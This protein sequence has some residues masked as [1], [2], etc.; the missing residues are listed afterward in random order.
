MGVRARAAQ[1]ANRLPRSALRLLSTFALAFFFLLCLR[2][3]T[4]P[5]S[6]ADFVLPRVFLGNV[7]MADPSIC[8]ISQ[9]HAEAFRTTA[10]SIFSI[11]SSGYPRLHVFMLRL[12]AAEQ[13][14]YT[15]IATGVNDML[16]EPLVSILKLDAQATT[17]TFP[18]APPQSLSYLAT[19]LAMELLM[20]ATVRDFC[21]TGWNSLVDLERSRSRHRVCDTDLSQPLC[22]YFLFSSTGTLFANVLIPDVLQHMRLKRVAIGWNFV[23]SRTW[24]AHT[25]GVC[26]EEGGSYVHMTAAFERTRMENDAA[27]VLAEH[28]RQRPSLRFMADKLRERKRVQEADVEWAGGAFFERLAAEPELR[29]EDLVLMPHAWMLRQ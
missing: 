13:K 5:P 4:L 16:G 25:V 24:P 11:S 20:A 2:A 29:K 22:D 19:D 10:A 26:P 28:L 7:S 23:S 14:V 12:D 17:A 3:L 8:V 21:A 6:D 27:L 18:D 1:A 15:D 9:T